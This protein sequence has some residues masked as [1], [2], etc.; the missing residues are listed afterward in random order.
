MAQPL[1]GITVVSLEHF[2]AAPF[3]TRQLAD[4]GA[5]VIK[6]E[7]P[8]TGDFA[9]EYDSSVAGS[10]SYFVWLNRS[11]ES[12]G[13]DIKTYEGREIL[14]E[15]VD[16]AD[17]VVQNLGPGAADRLGLGAAE[18]LRRD[19]QK[20]VLGISGWGSTGPWAD[21]KAYD[22]LAQC[23]TGLVSLTGTPHE[24]ARIGVSIA[25]IA[26]GVYGFSGVL[27]A[28]FQRE[29]TGVGTSVE[30]SLFEALAEWVGQPMHF[31][32]G[33]GV[34]PARSGMS[35]ATIVPYGPFMTADGQTVVISIQSEPEWQVF[36]EVVLEDRSVASRG[37]FTS[38]SLRVKH[39]DNLNAIIMNRF[40]NLDLASAVGLLEEAH[41]AYA[42]INSL[43]EFLE[44]PVLA[45]RDRWRPI[46]TPGGSVSALL[47][48]INFLGDEARMDPV[49]SLGEHTE[50]ILV[51]LG[52]SASEIARLAESLVVRIEGKSK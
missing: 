8:E 31:T 15:L 1:S 37:E 7:R 40:K 42:G 19:P 51:E 16:L 43:H 4:L 21:R 28:L 27:A 36:C 9:R 18:I 45:G 50:Q 30:V 35:H 38:N 2:V 52:R 6:V 39:R 47:P 34:S 12:I 11:K 41:V 3:A 20:I 32:M 13:L 29:R 33:S 46:D 26:A 10:S 23:E 44:H 17:V 22:L 49:P 5:R 24:P 25:D 48:P 14:H